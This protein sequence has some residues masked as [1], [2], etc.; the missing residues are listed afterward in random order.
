MQEH[1]E[2]L[3]DLVAHVAAAYFSNSHVGV[4]DIPAVINQIAVSLSGVGAAA[5]EA[6]VAQEP[7]RV[8]LTSAQVRRSITQEALISF[9][10]GQRYKTLKRHLSTRGLTP[11]QYVEKWGLPKNY[12]MVAPA[13]SERRSQLARA[14]GLGQKGGRPRNAKPAATPPKPKRRKAAPAAT[15][16]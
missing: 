8:K 14:A 6:E 9:E 13:Y 2:K 7:E 4:E 1:D 12:P 5:A 16:A 15:P 3:F 11:G 10:D